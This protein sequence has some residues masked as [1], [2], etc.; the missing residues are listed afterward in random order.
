MHVD[1][2]LQKKH[3]KVLEIRKFPCAAFSA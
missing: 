1:K 2:K 3:Q